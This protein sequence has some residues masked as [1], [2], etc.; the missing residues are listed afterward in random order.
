MRRSWLYVL[1][2]LSG[3]SALIYE[4]LWQRM[5]YLVVGVS[6]LAVSAVLAAFMGGLALGAVL[7]GRVADRT[8]RPLLLYA[9]LEAGVAVAALLTP[10]AVAAVSGVYTA[11]YAELQPG[12]WSGALLRLG[13]AAVVLLIPATLIGGT[14]PVMGR[15][16]AARSDG[17]SSSFGLL[18]GVNT[19]GGVAGATLTGF[20]FLHYL[21]MERTLWLAAGLNVVVAGA[22]VLA[23]RR[24]ECPLNAPEP[25]AM[26]PIERETPAGSRWWSRL[27]LTCAAITGAT[28]LGY[29]V[30]WTRILGIFTSNSA[31][32]FAL[33]LSV[34]LLGMGLGSL[35]HGW[36]ARRAGDPWPRLAG[37]QALLGGATL[38]VLPFFRTGPA[39]LERCSLADSPALLLLGELGLTAL[40]LLAP[41]VLLGTSFP[42]L[43]A[44]VAADPRRFGGWLG[45]V[46]AVNAVGCVAG[47]LATGV[48]L[49]PEAGLRNTL[50]LLAAANLLVAGI[51]WACAA[52]PSIAWRVAGGLAA[53]MLAWVAWQQFP[54]GGFTKAAPAEGQRLIYY[55]EGNNG[56]VSVMQNVYNGVSW[57]LV[58]GQPVAGTN[59]TVVIDQKMLAH[60]PLLL[61]PAPQRALTV[62]FGSGGTSHSMT[63]HEG[64]AVD[65]VEIEAAVPAAALNFYYENRNVRTHPRFRLIVDDARSWLRVA[66]VRYDVIATDCTNI[67][68]KS[69]GDL[70]TTDYFELM[71]SRLT[72]NGLA[73]AWVPANGI[74]A[75][76]LK[77]LL[78][79]FQ[80]V[81]PHTSV[82]FMNTLATDFLIVVGTPGKLE[83][84]L[85]R[86][87]ERMAAPA[88]RQ[89]LEAVHMEDPLRLA[90]T[91]LSADDDVRQ[92]VGSGPLNTDDRPVLSF[93]A[94]GASFRS[95]IARN[96]V[97]MMSCRSD[98]A[99]YLRTT[100]TNP[101]LLAQYAASNE[102][103]LGHV[104]HFRGD[105]R[106]ALRHYTIGAGL[107]P[108]DSSLQ[109]LVVTAYLHSP[110][111]ST[112]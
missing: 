87:R 81:F 93:S 27:A 31:Y 89:D 51:A 52:R 68:Y 59:R 26:P 92:Y 30:A 19:L 94:Y 35:L 29:E 97:E 41:A 110:A 111:A 46:Y 77:T 4:L 82:W 76:V 63:L 47:A 79:S 75:A 50:G 96:L 102:I 69:N 28:T 20:V 40:A 25:A 91:L 88:V 83:I 8:R 57:L 71:K 22:A 39:W 86:L 36:W 10:F 13:A 2:Y 21:G 73:A 18:Y 14:L 37:C 11:V 42:L 72:A 66:P 58:D 107:L 90:Y 98:A 74:D 112:P 78:R 17:L 105:E 33:M 55:A 34:V 108:G 95:T 54:V 65:C 100:E 70:Y 64:V 9:G 104:A 32:A 48:T 1:F 80:H 49:I 5:L 56:T 16:V 99:R 12:P 38:A 23:G 62:G 109:E 103:L 7:F 45:R 6:T 106:E 85:A 84:D 60:L 24:S 53:T 101:P 67:Q 43:A 3:A 61:H 15:L 44:G